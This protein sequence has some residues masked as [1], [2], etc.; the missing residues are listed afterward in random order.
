MTTPH[1]DDL[2]GKTVKVRVA[3]MAQ[4]VDKRFKPSVN[5][6]NPDNKDL[7][8]PTTPNASQFKELDL[9]ALI[10]KANQILLSFNDL[11]LTIDSISSLC[12]LQVA[13]T[14][15]DGMKRLA[16]E[17]V[18]LEFESQRAAASD[19]QEAN[20]FDNGNL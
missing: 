9:R 11:E 7:D 13:D 4:P 16:W 17:L 1:Y 19:F 6:H 3:E 5:P 2:I 20:C 14:K 18:R 12:D 8:W 10:Q 15:G